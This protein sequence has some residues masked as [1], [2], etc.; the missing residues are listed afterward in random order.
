M[1]KNLGRI[2]VVI[3]ICIGFI[4]AYLFYNHYISDTLGVALLTVSGILIITG[5]VGWCPLYQILGLS[6]C[7]LKN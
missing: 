4:L 1:R 6:T 7:K 2:D 3:R 5:F